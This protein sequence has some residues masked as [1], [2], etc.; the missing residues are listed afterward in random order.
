MFTS[1]DHSNRTLS[2]GSTSS[3]SCLATATVR[4]MPRYDKSTTFV[5]Y[6]DDDSMTVSDL[7]EMG[8]PL[9]DI[10]L[11]LIDSPW[12]KSLGWRQSPGLAELRSVRLTKPPVS[13]FWRYHD[14]GGDCVSSIETLALVCAELN[15][16]LPPSQRCQQ[17][18]TP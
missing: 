10:T 12:K 14:E 15:P 13:Q 6:P 7:R 8:R 3:S 16:E 18:L 1:D 2:R 17:Y 11:V 4:E 5:L 9:K